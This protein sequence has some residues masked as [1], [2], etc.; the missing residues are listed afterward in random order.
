M[1]LIRK[2]YELLYPE[3][4]YNLDARL[5]YSGKFSDYNANAR[6]KGKTLEIKISRKWQNVDEDIKIGLVQE[7]LIRLF[8]T[9][10]STMQ[11]ELYN[12]FLK[13]LHVSIPKTKT[14]PI[15]EE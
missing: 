13:N 7:L 8:K 9:K 12:H 3:K 10:K 6:L 4:E 14:H 15:L 11:I 1:D 2:S 5:V